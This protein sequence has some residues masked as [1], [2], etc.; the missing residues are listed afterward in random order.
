LHPQSPMRYFVQNA[1]G[2]ALC[3]IQVRGYKAKHVPAEK[4]TFYKFA[5]FPDCSTAV[6][7]QTI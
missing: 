6:R 4:G 1:S 2:D 5:S 7:L 3:T